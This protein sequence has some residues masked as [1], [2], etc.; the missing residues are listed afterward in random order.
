MEF[1]DL[2]NE[3]IFL[4]Q[5]YNPMP[6]YVCTSIRAAQMLLSQ[7]KSHQNNGEKTHGEKKDMKKKR[8][9]KTISPIHRI[10]KGTKKR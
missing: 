10:Y 4:Y 5:K 8:K 9:K 3:Q 1:K 6:C 2:E 7:S